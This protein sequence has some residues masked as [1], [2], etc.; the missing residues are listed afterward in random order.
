MVICNFFLGGGGGNI[1]KKEVHKSRV[2]G[3]GTTF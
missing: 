2:R 3:T 1:K